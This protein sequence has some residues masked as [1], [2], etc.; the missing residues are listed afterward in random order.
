MIF[1][2]TK[3]LLLDSYRTYACLICKP[4]SICVACL[5]IAC[6]Y[7]DYEP[8]Y[9]FYLYLKFKTTWKSDGIL[10]RNS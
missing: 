7:Y 4:L 6:S 8:Q 2:T 5:I 10:Q 9:I 3:I 1:Y